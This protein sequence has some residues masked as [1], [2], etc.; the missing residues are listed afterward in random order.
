M[1]V[2]NPA[3]DMQWQ[4]SIRNASVLVPDD[5]DEDDVENERFFRARRSGFRNSHA[6]S[7]FSPQS[8]HSETPHGHV[9]ESKDSCIEAT[10][11][12]WMRKV[13]NSQSK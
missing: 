8:C 7:S 9:E 1:F 11:Y 6:T 4:A 5:D 10:I 2:Q 12:P 3:F 13:Q